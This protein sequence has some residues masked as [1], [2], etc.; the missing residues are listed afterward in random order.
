MAAAA[1][2][3]WTVFH[4]RFDGGS[5]TLDGRAYP[6]GAQP[7]AWLGA[8]EPITDF[9]AAPIADAL[10]ELINRTG[11]DVVHAGPVPTIG[12]L[13]VE[14]SPVPVVVMSW[15]SDLLVDAMS[16][17]VIRDHASAALSRAS[18]VLV[19]CQTVA[20]LAIDLGADADRVVVV[21]WGVD[22]ELS[23][24]APFPPFDGPIRLLSLRTLE[25]LYDPECLLRGVALTVATCGRDSVR[26]TMAGS[27]S[28]ADDLRVL[29]ASLG[30]DQVVDW[31]G[32]IPEESVPDLLSQHHLHIST[33]LSDGSSISL[34]QAM[35]G[36]RPSVVTDIPAN[37]EWVDDGVNGWVFRPGDSGHLAEVLAEAL[38]RRGGL[39]AMGVLARQLA[40]QRADW[41]TN[42][43]VLGDLYRSVM[44]GTS[45]F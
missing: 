18:A 2:Q 19:D 25:P 23:T 28:M 30:I 7:S 1:A 31:I 26:L 39:P 43:L 4:A 14:A 33:A 34:L 27:G 5:S 38:D 35:A 6:P 32:R 11:A 40:D 3:G 9:T 29:S 13:A 36:A 17:E 44:R 24:P 8:S 22:L 37:R 16:S 42:S 20:N 10:A 21:P 45:R 12:R 15:A 41:S